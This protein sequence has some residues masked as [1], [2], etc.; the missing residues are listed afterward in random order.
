MIYKRKTP[1]SIE[2]GIFFTE[3]GFIMIRRIFLFKRRIRVFVVADDFFSP[4]RRF[5]AVKQGISRIG[6]INLSNA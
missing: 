6:Q 2:R 3:R 1:R 5:F 4:P